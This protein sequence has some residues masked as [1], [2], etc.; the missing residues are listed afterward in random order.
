MAFVGAV[1]LVGIS[2][3]LKRAS[4]SFA[5]FAEITFRRQNLILILR[6]RSHR[7]ATN[8]A[9]YYD[10]LGLGTVIVRHN[11]PH[12]RPHSARSLAPGTYAVKSAE[13]KCRGEE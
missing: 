3:L 9:E 2:R 4:L 13:G 7:F 11:S 6:L 10:G 12:P 5:E 1:I 8:G